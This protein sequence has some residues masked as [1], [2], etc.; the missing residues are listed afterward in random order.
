MDE[1]LLRFDRKKSYVLIDCETENLCLNHFHNLPWQ[2]AM[3][4]ARGDQIID[5]KHYY[6]RWDRP[7]NISKEAARITKFDRKKYELLA[8]PYDEIFPTIFDWLENTDYILGHNLLG[9]DMYLI[10]DFYD[11]MGKPY[12]H[13]IDKVIDTLSVARGIKNGRPYKPGEDFLEYQYRMI[14][15][16]R[17]GVKTTLA[18]LGQDYSIEYNEDD[19]HDALADL[20]LNFTVW[21]KLKWQIEI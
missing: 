12:H 1:H 20:K 9:F 17:K 7:I 3:I 21:N 19:L 5:T 13:L 15:L 18:Q 14:N 8:A 2:I 11:K 4:K 16:R 6:V 10:K